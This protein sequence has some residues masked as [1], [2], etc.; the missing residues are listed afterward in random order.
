MSR[1]ASKEN[2]L[3][4]QFMGNEW[5][6]YMPFCWLIYYFWG[7][8]KILQNKTKALVKNLLRALIKLN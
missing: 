4:C 7:K 8:N 6:M 3:V 2:K 5:A 1:N